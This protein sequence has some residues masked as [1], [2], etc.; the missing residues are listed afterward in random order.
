M[1]TLSPNFP[2]SSKLDKRLTRILRAQPPRAGS[3]AITVF[4][5][6]VSQHGNRIWLGSLVQALEAFGLNP[7]QIRTAVFRLGRE[8][9]LSAQMSGRKSFY[10]LTAFGRRQYELAARR[11]Y[12]L[13]QGDWNG[14]W[15]LVM[16]WQVEA[17]ARDELK[18]RLG[19]QG[20]AVLPSG[21]LA[22]PRAHAAPLSETL[23]DLSL[24]HR[25]I[26]WQAETA[27]LPTASPLA[28]MV[29]ACWN[30]DELGARFE[31]FI[32]TFAEVARLLE[33][34]ATLDPATAFRVRTLLVHQY[35][36]LLLRAT[37]LPAAL[38]PAAWPQR[39]AAD[40]AARIYRDVRGP[41][42]V[43]IQTALH[44]DEGTLPA[45][46]RTFYQRFGGF[47]AGTDA[48]TAIRVGA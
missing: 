16:P 37:D 5:D 14:C 25:V 31:D 42:L 2:N 44:N 48:D 18:R 43:Y 34:A 13:P 4:G 10:S 30:M 39:N 36:R 15:T 8:G 6:T 38:L 20:F 32:R 23:N 41:A 47:T 7:Q 28:E 24:T 29:R 9:W 17:P 21:V 11:I 12:G 22:H 40:L 3:L 45:P 46:D 27:A 19:W 35:R 1:S 26:V 33:Q